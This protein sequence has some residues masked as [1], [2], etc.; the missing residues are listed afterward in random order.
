MIKR[1]LFC[2]AVMLVLSVVMV[3]L[4]VS[5]Q[6]DKWLTA[7]EKNFVLQLSSKMQ[8]AYVTIKNNKA[9][10][11]EYGNIK[12]ITHITIMTRGKAS[13]PV[14]STL[15]FQDCVLHAPDTMSDIASTWNDEV[16]NE[17]GYLSQKMASFDEGV[18][19]LQFSADIVLVRIT[20][21]RIESSL[22]KIDKMTGEL[23]DDL[24]TTRET[25]EEAKKELELDD[26]FCFIATAAYGTPTAVEID[27]LRRFRDEYL[28]KN[29]LGNEFIKFYYANS[30][31]I[32]RYISEHETLRTMVREGFVEPV[33]EIIELTESGWAE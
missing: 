2:L 7:Y 9:W 33:V 1:I 27:E 8:E 15:F 13:F 16:C 17:F 26:D 3:P 20:L 4:S 21:G 23:V 31:P 14:P 32:A 29:Y 28:R 6:P 18:T 11:K 30:P 22:S 12:T 5:A 24:C 19:A 25:E 10:L